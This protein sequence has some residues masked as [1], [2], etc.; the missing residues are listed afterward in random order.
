VSKKKVNLKAT[1]NCWICEG[2]TQI[3]FKW[4][5]DEHFL[6]DGRRISDEIDDNTVCYIHLSCDNNEP[7]LMEKDESTGGF[8]LLRMVPPGVVNYYFS[9]A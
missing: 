3:L 7:D 6:D 4:N 5:P 1:S 2:W 8:T 9:I